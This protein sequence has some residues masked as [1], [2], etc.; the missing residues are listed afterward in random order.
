[1]VKKTAC[2]AG[3]QGLIFELGRSLG[4]GNGNSLQKSCLGNQKDREAWW[5][6]VHEV[7]E[8]RTRLSNQQFHFYKLNKQGDNTQPWCTPF[9]I[10]NQSALPCP[11]LTVAS[12][13]AYRFLRRQVRWSGTPISF[14]IF[15]FV[16]IHT[17]KGFS[18]VN[19]AEVDFFN[20]LAFSMIQWMLA[21]W[22]LVP[23]PFL[24]SACTSASSQFMYFWIWAWRILSITLLACEMSITDDSLS[25]LW[26]CLS[27]GWNENW[28]FSVLCPWLS[29]PNLLAYRVQHFNSIIF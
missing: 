14:R 7:T 28:P 16:V 4:E 20:P 15:Q 2:K 24:N 10:L 6:T 5:T 21:T 12:W 29:F 27:L 13:P 8:S 19:E 22:S 17:V 1:M 25:I 23:T 11:V 26:H 9:P 18:I 3:D